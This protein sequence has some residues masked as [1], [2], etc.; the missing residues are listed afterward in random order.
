MKILQISVKN[1]QDRLSFVL[2][3]PIA[4]FFDPLCCGLAYKL[5]LCC[6][7][8][9]RF[10]V[11]LVRKVLWMETIT[12]CQRWNQKT[13]P[14][15]T[16]INCISL[17]GM[18]L[19]GQIYGKINSTNIY[20]F[21]Y[22]K[23]QVRKHL[24]INVMILIFKLHLLTDFI[25]FHFKIYC[26]LKIKLILYLGMKFTASCVSSSQETWINQ[27]ILGVGFYYLCALVVLHLRNW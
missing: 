25:H 7:F 4:C 5:F 11:V 12:I 3:P 2:E 22:V 13:A 18:P 19:W 10:L 1:N 21:R 15:Q 8:F 20:F 17:L 16:L 14:Q 27:V 6:S 26:M 9:R 23:S 24:L